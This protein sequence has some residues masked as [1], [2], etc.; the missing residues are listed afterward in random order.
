MIGEA[1][2]SASRMHLYNSTVPPSVDPA[3]EATTMA[4]LQRTDA[5]SWVARALNAA[6]ATPGFDGVAAPYAAAGRKLKNATLEP[7][8]AESAAMTR[9]GADSLLAGGAPTAFR[10]LLLMTACSTLTDVQRVALVDRVFAT[11]DNDERIA[12]LC[13]LPFLPDARAYC[14]T[15]VEACRTNVRDVFTAIA[16]ENDYPSRYF[17]DPAFNQLVMK[18]LFC[19]VELGRIRGLGARVN[20]ELRRMATDYASERRAAGRPVPRDIALHLDGTRS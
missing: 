15:A 13:A 17:T 10:A 9:I 11:G 18:A 2:L 6:V 14:A 20:A 3:F 16:C 7:T 19:D 1:R 5:A 4:L 8:S 12:L